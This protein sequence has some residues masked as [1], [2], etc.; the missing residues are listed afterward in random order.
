MTAAGRRHAPIGV[1]T[2]D[3]HL[4]IS[5]VK[6]QPGEFYATDH[7]I[8]IVTV[9]GS[10]VAA[11]LRDR[12]SGIGGLNHF[13]LP[14]SGRDAGPASTSARYG[15]NAMELL[16]NELIHLGARRRNLEAKVFGGGNMLEGCTVLNIGQANARFVT[17]FL[18][19]ES[20]P[21]AGSDL[22]G[23]GS[24]KVCFFPA[25]GRVLVR[26]IDR[27]AERAALAET[28]ARYGARLAQLPVAGQT[29]IFS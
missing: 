20:I 26:G 28:E 8:A 29:E 11:C 10:C 9:L 17:E 14:H 3:A 6:V 24:R 4:R 23:N 1:A 27:S 18:R 16:I 25:T 7:D 2:W 12:E 15:V 5:A 22:E 21:V 13:M 19:A